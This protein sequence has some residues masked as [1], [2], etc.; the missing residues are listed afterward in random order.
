VRQQSSAWTGLIPDLLDHIYDRTGKFLKA[1]LG[2]AG[3][4]ERRAIDLHR[5]DA[6]NKLSRRAVEK[7]M[8]FGRSATLDLGGLAC[9][10]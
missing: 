7:R 4:Q 10:L 9:C 6:P 3:D 5:R 8:G 1:V 2:L